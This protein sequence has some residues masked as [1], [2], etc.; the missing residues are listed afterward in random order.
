MDTS[1]HD[2]LPQDSWNSLFEYPLDGLGGPAVTELNSMDE[3]LGVG[4]EKNTEIEPSLL[5]NYSRADKPRPISPLVGGIQNYNSP[6]PST[7]ADPSHGLGQLDGLKR[8]SDNGITSEDNKSLKNTNGVLEYE[9]KSNSGQLSLTPS[10]IDF[11]RATG[12][13]NT[14]IIIKKIEQAFSKEVSNQESHYKFES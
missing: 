8:I 13:K 4:W 3:R 2:D 14:D 5:L 7:V 9:R 10:F 6:D 12:V 11:I 1:Y